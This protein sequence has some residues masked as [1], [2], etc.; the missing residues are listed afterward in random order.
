MAIRFHPREFAKKLAPKKTI[1]K[2]VKGNLTVNRAA[3]TMLSQSGVLKKKTLEEVAIKVINGYKEKYGNL[4]NE[5]ATA[6]EA[7]EEALNGKK[8]LV[9]RVQSAA[10][11]EVSKKVKK[12]YRGEFYEWLPSDADE[13][14]PIH[15]LNYGEVFQLGKGEAP[16]D[17]YGCQCGMNILVDEDK[18]SL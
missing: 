4:R 16:G 7:K 6:S 8:Q 18:L 15:Q 11:H 13:P 14:D 10:T 9:E 1:Q 3:A 17:R 2:L 12:E 5:G